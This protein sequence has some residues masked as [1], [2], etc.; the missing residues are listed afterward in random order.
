VFGWRAWD[1]AP[2]GHG[3]AGLG[4][5]HADGRHYKAGNS[6]VAVLAGDD[7]I[8]KYGKTN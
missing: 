7:I 1:R 6:G 3:A 4:G 8:A 2:A 5:L